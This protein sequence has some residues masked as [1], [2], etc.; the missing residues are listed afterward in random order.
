LSSQ[1]LGELLRATF[2]LRCYIRRYR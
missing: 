2:S 1:V